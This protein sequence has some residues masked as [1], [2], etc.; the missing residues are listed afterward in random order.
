MNE[1]VGI[2]FDNSDRITYFYTNNLEIKKNLTVIVDTD[3]GLRFGK[4]ITEIHPINEKKL[5]K[6]LNKIVRIASSQD[7]HNY[8]KNL[9]D[10][11]KAL[12]KCEELAKNYNLD[13]KIIDTYYTHDRDQLVFKFISDNRIDFR[14]LAR[15]LANIYHTRIELRQIGVRDKAKEISGIGSCGQKLCCSRFLNEFN[16][17]SIAMAKNQNLALNPSKINGLCGRL[18]CCLKYEDE[19]YTECRKK[20]PKIGQTISKSDE[21]EGK[22]ISIDIL[23]QKYQ[24]E[25]SS[26]IIE[27]KVNGSN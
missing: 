24:I 21:K 25:T 1:I 3:N 15:D 12:K 26:G 16:S 11:K 7:Y 17:V 10:A 6:K 8:Q 2:I 27:E 5:N 18:L 13:M 19:C 23:K 22:V 20:L 4:V 9:K 14:D